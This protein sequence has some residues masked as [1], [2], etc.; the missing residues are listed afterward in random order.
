MKSSCEKSSPEQIRTAVPRSRVCAHAL[1]FQLAP[2][3]EKID[4]VG[5]SDNDNLHD[6]VVFTK[7]ELELFI[8]IKSSG[9]SERSIQVIRQTAGYIWNNTHGQINQV[10]LL[11]LSEFFISTYPHPS[12]LHKCF[13]YTRM[14]LMHLYK[15]RRDVRLMSYHSLFEKP[16]NRRGVKMLTSRIIVTEDIRSI[17]TAIEENRELSDEIKDNYTNQILFLAY[18]GQRPVTTG[19]LTVTQFREALTQQYPVLKVESDQDKLRM[20]HLVPIHPTIIPALEKF[21]AERPGDDTMFKYLS[22]QRFLK[23]HP[24]LMKHTR[25]SIE[26]K[27]L[28]KFFEQKSDEVGFTDANKNFIMSHGCGSINWQSY[29]QFLPETLYQNYISKWGDVD[30]LIG[31]NKSSLLLA[32]PTTANILT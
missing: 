29:K 14:F 30:L 10:S 28:R 5:I 9:L 25:G 32:C 31:D 18:S 6:T 17:L 7:A 2:Q 16:K 4:R 8:N 26:L 22:L 27:D 11:K 1:H 3:I 20:E 13:V 12:A 19:R 24:V 21:I 15:M 23:N